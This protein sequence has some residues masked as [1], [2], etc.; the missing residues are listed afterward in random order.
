[1]FIVTIF[2]FERLVTDKNL[3]Y[4]I[5]MIPEGGYYFNK[6]EKIGNAPY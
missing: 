1:M 2:N 6:W 4:F 5:C 3:P